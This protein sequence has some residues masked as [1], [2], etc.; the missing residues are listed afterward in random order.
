MVQ[1]TPIAI[2]VLVK[3]GFPRRKP[4]V[5]E[6]WFS[7]AFKYQVICSITKI[8]AF[9]CFSYQVICSITK[10]SA[11]LRVFQMVALA[12]FFAFALLSLKRA[13]LDLTKQNVVK[14]LAHFVQN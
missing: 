11:F 3:R 6:N 4:A 2:C 8:S 7:V 14:S 12:T 10:I 5:N 9:L 1:E 13:L